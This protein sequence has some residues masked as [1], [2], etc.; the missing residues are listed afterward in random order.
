MSF[1]AADNA[2][3]G[4]GAAPVQEL[5]VSRALVFTSPQ[6]NI[7]RLAFGTLDASYAATSALSLQGDVYFRYFSQ[8][9]SNGNTTDY[10]ACAAAPDLGKL[11]QGDGTTPLTST[12]GGP[13]PD[14]S[15]GGVTPIGENDFEAIRSLG[16]GG[17]LQLTSSTPVAAR[18]NQFSAGGSIDHAE[19]DFT[20]TAEVGVIDGVLQVV[21]SG[22]FVD[23]PENTPFTATPVSLGASS[24]YYGLWVTDTF[25]PTARLAI[26]ASGRYNLA[27]ID[28]T[29][30]LGSALSGD[31]RYA[32]FNPALGL[33]Y[34]LTAWMTFYGGYAEANR[35]P[36]PGEIECSNPEAPCLLPS[37]L[38]SDPPNLKQVVSHTWE[39]GLRGR[40][41]APGGAR[42]T[43]S[44]GLFR[45]NVDDDIYGVATSL[46]AGYFQNIGGTRRAGAELAVRYHTGRI[47]AYASYSFIDA[48]FQSSLLLPSP[49]NPYQDADGNI[50]VRPGDQLP[51]IP[52]GRFKAGGDVEI[53]RHF[54]IGADL[55][56]VS[57]QY[58]GGDKSNQ[59]APLPG[60]AV[61]D[62]YSRY[63]VTPAFQHYVSID[64]LF[65]AKYASFGVLGDP[66]GIGAQ[67]VPPDGVTNGPGVNNRFQSPAAPIAIYG[68]VRLNF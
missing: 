64:N 36:S 56:V 6:E 29:D 38:S 65:N 55:V 51:G 35:A 9:V 24:S 20:S 26:T 68:G 40:L 58:Y 3:D 45:A 34:D 33:T 62:L 12:A 1:S 28:L 61:V 5:A 14:I 43:W 59:L 48:T 23:T 21:P 18:A 42:L 63:H 44:A 25:S 50:Q 11:C 7:D 2:L 22:Y 57:S 15:D 67:G 49:S 19:T 37:S 16:V 47:D 46:S 60:Y 8:A 27:V 13:I 66:T 32:R 31:N 41:S 54:V 39:A 10:T 30:R 17:S 52:Q 53:F 4:Q